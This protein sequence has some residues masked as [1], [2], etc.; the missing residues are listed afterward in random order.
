MWKSIREKWREEEKRRRE[1]EQGKEKL[2]INRAISGLIN[3]RLG[4]HLFISTMS[5][6]HTLSAGTRVTE[7]LP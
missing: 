5:G 2:G 3:W 4:T 7:M 6:F 1:S